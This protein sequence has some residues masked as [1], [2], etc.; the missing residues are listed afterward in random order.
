MDW[1][2]YDNGLRHERYLTAKSRQ[3]FSKRISIEEFRLG[4]KY[5][6]EEFQTNRL[7][8]S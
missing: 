4:S 3:L 6:S 7:T 5:A 1:F 2:L 8:L